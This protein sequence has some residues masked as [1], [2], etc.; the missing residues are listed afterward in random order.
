MGEDE[1]NVKTR[2]YTISIVYDAFYCTPRVFISGVDLENCVLS[3][4]D[5]FQDVMSDYAHKTVTFETMPPL[6]QKQANIHPCKHSE[7]LLKIMGVM[8]GNGMEVHPHM[9]LF[10]FLKFINSIMPT[11]DFD[12]TLDVY[13]A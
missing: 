11:L 5:I 12:S 10:I 13:I 1:T 6:N 4:E 8:R 2:L 7:A 9:V 3:Q